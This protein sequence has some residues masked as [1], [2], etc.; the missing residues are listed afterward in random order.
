MGAGGGA[1][2][3]SLY[4]MIRAGLSEGETFKQRSDEREG[5]EIR[6]YLQREKAT[7]VNSQQDGWAYRRL[8]AAELLQKVGPHS[9]ASS[10]QILWK[11][12]F[13]FSCCVFAGV[14]LI[15]FFT[16]L[17]PLLGSPGSKCTGPEVKVGLACVRN[18]GWRWGGSLR[19]LETFAWILASE[20][21][22][23]HWRFWTETGYIQISL[24]PRML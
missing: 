21:N 13:S 5:C 22:G 7:Q 8:G 6:K 24:S 19:A 20:W 14:S 18:I 16:R 2:Y 4:M 1:W 3:S 9:P 12:F 10:R 17:W 23:K 11:D 15:S